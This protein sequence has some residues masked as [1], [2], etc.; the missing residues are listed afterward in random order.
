MPAN[1][2]CKICQNADGNSSFMAREMMF[3]LKDEFEYFECRSCGC[4][5]L[6]EIPENISKYYPQDYY[7]FSLPK[8][9]SKPPTKLRL[10]LRK[11]RSN[12]LLTQKGVIGKIFLRLSE[13]YFSGSYSWDWFRKSGN[14]LTSAILD[15][16]CGRGKLLRSLGAEGFSNL[17]GIDPYIEQDMEFGPAGDF[18]IF[19]KR[20]D[21]LEGSFDLIMLHHS[22]EHMS[23]PLSTMKQ[24]NRLLK[25]NQFALIRIP[26]SGS[27]AWKKYGA[28]WVQLDAPRHFFLHTPASIAILAQK[29]GF[30]LTET[31]Y[32]STD[33]QFI[34]SELYVRNIPLKDTKTYLNGEGGETFSKEILESFKDESIALNMKKEGDQACFF[35]RKVISS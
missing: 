24:I 23:D 5:Q 31:V 25:P 6:S 30:E 34:G 18:K 29:S 1:L 35:L 32:D 11:S 9:I 2:C 19:K 33:F 20:L 3:G 26:L 14:G 17:T 7:S 21:Q 28:S 12:F 16:G 13:D 8:R 15:V 10:Y 4:L 22:F 27:Y